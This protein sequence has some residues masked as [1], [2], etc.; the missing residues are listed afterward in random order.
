MLQRGQ[1]IWH[2]NQL[3]AKLKKDKD[4]DIEVQQIQRI[5]R[6]DLGLRYRKAR[7]VPVQANSERCLVM[8][9]QYALKM[10]ELHSQDQLILSL[11]ET[12]LNSVEHSKRMWSLPS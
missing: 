10:F 6:R 12:W 4:L 11:D 5:L 2:S 7:S 1:P 3:K 9:Q 8:R